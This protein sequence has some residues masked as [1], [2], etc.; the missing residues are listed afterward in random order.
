M[1]NKYGKLVVGLGLVLMGLLAGNSGVVVYGVQTALESRAHT[2]S[3]EDV[4]GQ[5]TPEQLK[6][7]SYESVQ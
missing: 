2:E 1:K 6:G 7:E 4:G 3:L 5:R